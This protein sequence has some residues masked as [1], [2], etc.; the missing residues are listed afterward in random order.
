[1]TR[2][3]DA[4]AVAEGR[5]AKARKVECIVADFLGRDT[6]AGLRIL[7]VGCGSGHF[8]AQFAAR[9]SVAAVDIADQRSPECRGSF[10]FHQVHSEALPFPDESFDLV[11]SN[12]VIAYLPDQ[13]RHLAE[14]ARVLRASGLAYF[15]APNRN[16]PLEPHHHVPFVHYLPRRAYMRALKLLGLYRTDVY[17][18]THR[19]LRMMA[20][21]AGLTPHDY[22]VRI[23]RD[24]RRY[25]MDTLP[26]RALP[27]FVS[28]LSPTNIFV[29]TKAKAPP[30]FVPSGVIEG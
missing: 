15:A 11:V 17:L 27:Q 26:L 28:V 1:M 3:L 23:L 9:N 29:L 10:E 12:H 22:T 30:R 2:Y 19:Q 7:D 16:F 8:A 5:A 6:L 24:P 14:I 4:Y 13:P 20:L 18:L 25:A 21:H